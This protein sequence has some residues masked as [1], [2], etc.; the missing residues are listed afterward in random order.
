MALPSKWNLVSFALCIF[1]VAHAV[2]DSTDTRERLFGRW[3]RVATSCGDRLPDEVIRR[4]HLRTYD[5]MPVGAILE[6]DESGFQATITPSDLCE[7]PPDK[8][9]RLTDDQLVFC[10]ETQV[11]Q[12]QIEMD[13]SGSNLH[14]E[15]VFGV[16]GWGIGIRD[17]KVHWYESVLILS[18]EDSSLCLLSKR[19]AW[20]TYWVPW[21]MG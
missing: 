9:P 3:L 19:G 16:N 1:A 14:F 15:T 4:L 5:G 11:N 21:P 6:F 12:G 18:E 17:V 8:R 2:A 10:S 7:V 13:S 20:W